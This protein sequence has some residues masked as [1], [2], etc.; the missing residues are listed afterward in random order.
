MRSVRVRLLVDDLNALPR[1]PPASC[2]R[3]GSIRTSRG[4]RVQ[5]FP[6]AARPSG[7][8]SSP[9]YRIS[10]AS[11]S[12]MHNKLFVADN[13]LAI[14]GG[15]NIGDEYFTLD[16]HSN[17]IDLDLVG[18]G[19]IVA[20]QLSASFDALLEQRSS[21]YPIAFARRSGAG[22]VPPSRRKSR[23]RRL[24]GLRRRRASPR[25][26]T[27]TGCG[28]SSD[29]QLLKLIWAP[30]HRTAD[31][32]WPAEDRKRDVSPDQGRAGHHRE[33]HRHRAH[34]LRA[35]GDPRDLAVLRGAGK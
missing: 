16:T 29:A 24:P 6:G 12:R 18:A 22:R 33:Q 7:A 13:A 14:T 32:H 9:R 28:T 1:G 11:T 2:V 34:A 19:P 25:T 15:R 27:P 5:P 26:S 23:C 10:R 30:R 21:A 3:Q 4:A 31:R 8:A 20:P 35:T 17:T